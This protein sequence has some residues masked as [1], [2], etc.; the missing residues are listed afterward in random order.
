MS[1]CFSNHKTSE[2]FNLGVELW[3]RKFGR[4]LAELSFLVLN[5]GFV[6]KF[7]RPLILN[8]QQ[9][10]VILEKKI[11]KF[12]RYF[13]L[14]LGQDMFWLLIKVWFKQFKFNFLSNIKHWS[15]HTFP[16]Y[17]NTLNAFIYLYDAFDA[18]IWKKFEVV[19]GHQKSKNSNLNLDW[20]FINNYY[21]NQPNWTSKWSSR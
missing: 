20:I 19:L 13:K 18:N 11:S 9:K 1:F 21:K 17:W 8:G 10:L 15:S 4:K 5:F 3:R 6:R 12:F 2:A 14:G 7:Y 16:G